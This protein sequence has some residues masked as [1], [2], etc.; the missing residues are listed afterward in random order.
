VVAV[1]PDGRRIEGGLLG[2]VFVIWAPRGG[3]SGSTV[4]AYQGSQRV[5]DGLPDVLAGSY[6]APA[7]ARICE[8]DVLAD[9][10][11]QP[12]IP[13]AER[14]VLPPVRLT[15]VRG[16]T[17]LWLYGSRRYLAACT[18]MPPTGFVGVASAYVP[19][20]NGWAPL[21]HAAALGSSGWV[22][23]A[24]PAGAES[25]EVH[26]S[27]GRTVQADVRDGFF[28]ATWS[29]ASDDADIDRIV[30]YTRD[31]VYEARP[32]GRVTSHPR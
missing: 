31:T 5:A 1:A 14:N 22:F 4:E 25:V 9:L 2:G 11:V 28:T 13:D 7:F 24:A 3:L 15:S 16:D 30:A 17:W 29:G 20:G 21:Q 10:R 27:D 8:A 32:G 6:D 19:G 23:G 26:L 18:R 12:N